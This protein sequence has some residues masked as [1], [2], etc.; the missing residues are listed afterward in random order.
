MILAFVAAIV[1]AALRIAVVSL[2][3]QTAWSGLD[4]ASAMALKAEFKSLVFFKTD[5]NAVI[6]R[7]QK[8]KLDLIELTKWQSPY[9]CKMLVAVVDVV[10]ELSCQQYGSQN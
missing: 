3:V 8:L 4:E 2:V 1:F 9:L 10:V 5:E 6:N 7:L